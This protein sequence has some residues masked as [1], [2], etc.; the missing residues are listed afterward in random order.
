LPFFHPINFTVP[1]WKIVGKFMSQ[2][3]TRISLPVILNEPLN[4]LQKMCEMQI[5]HSI[6]ENAANYM[7]EQGE[8]SI[9]YSCKRLISCT[10]YSIL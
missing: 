3:L 1:I 6:L 4:T 10:L 2:D 5:N 8:D 7:P 9:Q